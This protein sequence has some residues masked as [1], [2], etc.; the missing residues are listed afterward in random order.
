MLLHNLDIV[1]VLSLW[2][3]SSLLISPSSV[4]YSDVGDWTDCTGH[5]I[6]LL[7]LSR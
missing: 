2:I 3:G 7:L 6:L 4:C 1:L 5:T